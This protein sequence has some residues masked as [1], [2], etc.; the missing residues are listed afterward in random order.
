MDINVRININHTYRNY[1]KRCLNFLLY[2]HLSFIIINV[3]YSY[4][5][6]FISTGSNIL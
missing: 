5:L 1:K 3:I 4:E 2:Y 6:L